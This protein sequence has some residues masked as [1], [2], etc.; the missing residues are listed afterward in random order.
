M[1]DEIGNRMKNK[2]ERATD[3]YLPLKSFQIIRIDGRA[4]HTYT[5]R[6]DKPRDKDFINI[7]NNVMIKSFRKIQNCIF[8][9]TQSDE[10]N[11]ILT[12]LKNH[13]SQ[14]FFDGK[15]QKIASIS[16]STITALFAQEIVDFREN[17]EDKFAKQ[18]SQK[19]PVFDARTFS[20]PS[21]EEAGNYL[22]WRQLDAERNWV[23]GW[24][25]TL[26]SQKQLNGL[27]RQEQIAIIESEGIDWKYD[28]WRGY[29]VTDYVDMQFPFK[30][31]TQT[32]ASKSFLKN[33]NQTE[34]PIYQVLR[35][36]I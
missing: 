14:T 8:A 5:K 26:R 29:E 30:A 19:F 27:G 32:K 34:N 1:Y 15:I 28:G 4:F 9:Y 10:I 2:H 3:Y 16:A 23:A 33:V 18:W 7:M 13:E 35:D 22:I 25:Q 17:N 20:I 11:Y 12:D 24:A 21:V 6:L 36:R 31:V